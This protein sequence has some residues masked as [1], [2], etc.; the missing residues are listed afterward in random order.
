MINMVRQT[1]VQS[2]FDILNPSKMNILFWSDGTGAICFID[3]LSVLV[4]HRQTMH[5]NQPTT[6]T[7]AA[8]VY[9]K[10]TQLYTYLHV[11]YCYNVIIIIKTL[12]T[13]QTL[14]LHSM[15]LYNP[16]YTQ[17]ST[18]PSFLQINNFVPKNTV[19]C[20]CSGRNKEFDYLTLF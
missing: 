16:S 3:C 1:F 19:L 5:S 15:L 4:S 7:I 13:S 18:G 14:Q 11:I 6:G 2:G 17:P 9:I 8:A 12:T 20:W 10:L